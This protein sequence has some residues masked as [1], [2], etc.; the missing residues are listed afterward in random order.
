MK[1]PL[2]RA[3]TLGT[4]ALIVSSTTVF[5]STVTTF[6]KW[7]SRTQ[8]LTIST[9]S[10][11]TSAWTSGA[12]TVRNNTNYK[13]STTLGATSNYYAFDTTNSS[14]TWDGLTGSTVTGGFITNSELRLNTYYTSASKYTAAIKAGV[15]AHEIG[16]S[17][18]LN[19]SSVVETSSF[20]HPYTFDSNNTPVRPLTP[21]SDDISVINALYPALKS[22]VTTFSSKSD[23]VY[24]EPSWAVYYKDG[25][26][27]TEAADVVVRGVINKESGSM[28]KT[29]GE[30]HT[31]TTISEL[32][33]NE[34]LKGNTQVDSNIQI[35]QM[36]GTDGSVKVIGEHTSLLKKNQE[37]LLFLKKIDFN[38]YIPINEDDSIFVLENEKYKNIYNGSDLKISGNYIN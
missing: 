24:L 34:V 5:A 8:T 19:H 22:S 26:E 4:L 2:F 31:Y 30:Y 9:S 38:T 28:F 25:D 1:K 17:L 23:G 11:N 33:V 3:V 6:S 7:S 13:V 27:L 15:A 18:G 21:S 35:A 16:H 36:G 29:R 14:V 12:S 20:M 32:K 10:G 37:V